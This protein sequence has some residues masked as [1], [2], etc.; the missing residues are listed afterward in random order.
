[1]SKKAQPTEA[2]KKMAERQGK[3]YKKYSHEEAIRK[4][5]KSVN[6]KLGEVDAE[7]SQSFQQYFGK[8]FMAISGLDA[9]ITPFKDDDYEGKVSEA[10]EEGSPLKMG[11][12]EKLQFVHQT[13]EEIY[14]LLD[15]QKIFYETSTGRETV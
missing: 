13:L 3:E 12:L 15:R 9:V 10:L 2:A 8:V 6:E 7:D 14:S 5:I 1:M 4:Q 11:R